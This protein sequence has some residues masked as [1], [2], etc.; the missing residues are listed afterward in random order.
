VEDINATFCYN[1]TLNIDFFHQ[2]L[3]TKSLAVVCGNT[4]FLELHGAEKKV[5]ELG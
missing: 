4:I 3:Q 1:Y 5:G 2:K